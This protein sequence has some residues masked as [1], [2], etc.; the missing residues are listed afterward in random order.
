MNYERRICIG[1]PLHGTVVGFPS[2]N[3]FME[4]PDGYHIETLSG[5]GFRLEAIIHK[6][7]HDA[8]YKAKVG[9]SLAK[10]LLFGD[11]K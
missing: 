10:R 7:E 4:L 3:G 11:S 8:A 1:G 9:H 6:D 2:E 5:E